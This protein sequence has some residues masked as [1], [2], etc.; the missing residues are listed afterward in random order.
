MIGTFRLGLRH[1]PSQRAA[2]AG[3][4]LQGTKKKEGG[5]R[6]RF[7]SAMSC[8]FIRPPPN[9]EKERSKWSFITGL[10]TINWEG[11]VWFTTSPEPIR[12]MILRND[13]LRLYPCGNNQVARPILIYCYLEFEEDGEFEG[14]KGFPRGALPGGG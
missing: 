8:R 14:M 7:I 10:Q 3:V 11:H 5:N 6:A 1:L 2:L 12:Q 9:G 13:Y 4:T